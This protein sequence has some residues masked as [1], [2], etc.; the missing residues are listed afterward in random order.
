MI[1][2]RPGV[3]VPPDDLLLQWITSGDMPDKDLI[4]AAAWGADEQ[5]R[6]CVEWLACKSFNGHWIG[7]S[8][9]TELES[10]MRPEPPKE[11]TPKELRD[12]ALQMLTGLL[13][14][15]N[16]VLLTEVREAMIAGVI[17]LETL[18]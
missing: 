11:L 8:W 15:P 7:P 6:L 2:P 13:D 3:P 14:D 1:E 16:R 18:P 4:V 5:L 12:K 9:A 17:A 10:A